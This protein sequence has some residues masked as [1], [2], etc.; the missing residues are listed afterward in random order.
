M[1]PNDSKADPGSSK[2]AVSAQPINMVVGQPPNTSSSPAIKPGESTS[3]WSETPP[4]SSHNESQATEAKASHPTTE[5]VTTYKCAICAGPANHRCGRCVEGVDMNGK[6]SPTYY[7]GQECQREH[8]DAHKIECGSSIDRNQLYRIGSI[9]QWAFYRG[10]EVTWH[11]SVQ[12]VMKIDHTGGNNDPKMLVW[13]SKDQR[14][15]HFAKF[16]EELFSEEREKQAVLAHEAPGAL[17][18]SILM[19]LLG[20]GLYCP[21]L[22][23]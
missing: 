23:C 5:E 17:V 6:K 19:M 21:I 9:L 16:H 7:C 14:G 18:V 10:R 13:C 12:R 8:W 4:Q 15:A 2:A 20:E 1:S 3:Y 22:D 11:Q